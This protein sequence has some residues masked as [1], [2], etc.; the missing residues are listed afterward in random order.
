MQ[1]YT[2]P[3]NQDTLKDEKTLFF[4]VFRKFFPT[5]Q[6]DFAFYMYLCSTGTLVE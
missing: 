1:R 3:R 2:I 4:E 5:V 6:E